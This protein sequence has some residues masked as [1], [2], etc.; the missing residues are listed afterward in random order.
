VLASSPG[1][2]WPRGCRGS[3]KIEDVRAPE[4]LAR[5]PERTGASRRG[6]G[7]QDDRPIEPIGC[8]SAAHQATIP[9]QSW[10]MSVARPPAGRVDSPRRPPSVVERV[11]ATVPG[12]SLRLYP[13]GRGSRPDILPPPALRSV[14]PA[15]PELGETV[16]EDDEGASSGP[17]WATWSVT[18]LRPIARESKPVDDGHAVGPRCRDLQGSRRAATVVPRRT[19]PALGS[20]RHL[21][22]RVDVTFTRS[23]PSPSPQ[24]RRWPIRP[25]EGPRAWRVASGEWRVES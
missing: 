17:A 2:G 16:Q 1:A 21:P 19:C 24:G 20:T 9:P 4:E 3:W 7:L 8:R 11:R 25:V 15:V 5:M 13:A 22:R 23:F 10:P 14:P 6:G 12:L 18:P